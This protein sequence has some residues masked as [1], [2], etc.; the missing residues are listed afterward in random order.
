VLKKGT[1]LDSVDSEERIPFPM[2]A[3]TLLTEVPT[4]AL[5]KAAAPTDLAAQ[6]FVP[7]LPKESH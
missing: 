6:L 7:L 1:D 2:A 5:L 3:F 4:A